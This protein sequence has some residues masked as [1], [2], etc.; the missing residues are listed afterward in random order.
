MWFFRFWSISA[1]HCWWNHSVFFSF[2][3]RLSARSSTA[4]IMP[5][6]HNLILLSGV[7]ASILYGKWNF[8]ALTNYTT[9]LW[10]WRMICFHVRIFELRMS[11]LK[12]LEVNSAFRRSSSF[13]PEYIY[14]TFV[15]VTIISQHWFVTPLLGIS[16]YILMWATNEYLCCSQNVSQATKSLYQENFAFFPFPLYLRSST[17]SLFLC[18]HI[19]R[20]CAQHFWIN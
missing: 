10:L 17:T 9:Y 12:F 16:I 13:S 3:V 8:L 20:S 18:E 6:L 5:T 2:F 1:F 4:R 7:L 14:I 11:E 15:N 19:L